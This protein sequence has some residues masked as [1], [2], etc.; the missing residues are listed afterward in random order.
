MNFYNMD[1][2]K[3]T[4]NESQIE[5]LITAR[6]EYFLTPDE[7]AIIGKLNSQGQPVFSHDQIIYLS[8]VVGQGYTDNHAKLVEKMSA[9]DD[10][11]K[12]VFDYLQMA[13]IAQAYLPE[14]TILSIERASRMTEYLLDHPEYDSNMMRELRVGNEHYLEIEDMQLF[15]QLDED[16]EPVFDDRRA[17]ALRVGLELCMKHLKSGGR[18]LQGIEIED[19]MMCAS[20]DRAGN[21]VFTAT[22]IEEMVESLDE[23]GE[24]PGHLQSMVS[25]LYMQRSIKTIPLE[26]QINSLRERGVLPERHLKP[27]TKAF[28]DMSL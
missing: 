12:P 7:M 24:F 4:Y 19:L 2:M 21:P 20:I 25:S 17:N 1:E 13:E 11:E 15:A 9:L 6:E 18:L 3:R 5:A 28:E 27:E 10:N 22:E 23:F 26:K 14:D 16:G 8:A